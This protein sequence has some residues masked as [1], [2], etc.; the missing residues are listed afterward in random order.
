MALGRR[1]SDASG[2]GVVTT[3]GGPFL[4]DAEFVQE[5]DDLL[6]AGADGRTL[7]A[8]N[9]FDGEQPALQT[10]H[11][12]VL[13]AKQVEA[14]VRTPDAD[15]TQIAQVQAPSSSPIGSIIDLEGSVSVRHVNGQQDVLAEGDSVYE[16]DLLITGPAGSAE[17]QF[18]DETKF[19]IGP[20]G[21]M[22]LDDFVFNPNTGVGEMG[23]SVVQGLFRFVSGK[24]AHS[25]EDN[26]LVKL[27]TGT[28]GIRGTHVVGQAAAEGYENKVTLLENPPPPGSPPG[29]RADGWRDHLHHIGGQPPYHRSKRHDLRPEHQPASVG[30][31]ATDGDTG[32]G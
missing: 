26:M 1:M 7:V 16:D 28:I 24:V 5:G 9:Y 21:R 20:N 3:P 25:G 13:S 23:V 19:S 14:L 15:I 30:R 8:Q 18:V 32:R 2:A 27:P 11:G 6:I 29:D 31:S 22:T 12:H 17:I 10:D 4:L